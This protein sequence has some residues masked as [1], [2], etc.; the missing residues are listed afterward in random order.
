[1]S[2]LAI[3]KILAISGSQ[4]AA[5]RLAP[6]DINVTLYHGLGYPPL[7][8]PNIEASDASH[9][10]SLRRQIL[11]GDALLIASPE[12]ADGVAGK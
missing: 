3:V 11:S 10:A 2:S 8:N 4:R 6:A 12:Y 9:V 5:V 1:V 7:F